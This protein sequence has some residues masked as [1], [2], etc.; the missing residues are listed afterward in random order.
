MATREDSASWT[1]ACFAEYIDW[2]ADHPSDD[3]MTDLLNA[4]FEDETGDGAEPR[5]DEILNYIGSSPAPG[6]ETTTRLIGWAGKVLAE[7][8]DQRRELADDPLARPR[9]DRGAA[10]LRVAFAGPGPLRDPRRGAPRSDGARGQRAAADQRRRQPGRAQVRRPDRFDIHREHQQH[11]TFGYGIH[12]CL[13]AAWPGSRVALRS[14]RSS[15]ASP[16]G[17]STGTTPVQAHTSTVRGW[18]SLPVSVG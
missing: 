17:R 5:P 2:R 12:F 8:P 15:S 13:G 10:A 3:L 1:G 18:E 16:N 4:E 6:N 11:L 14:K 9:S 7:H